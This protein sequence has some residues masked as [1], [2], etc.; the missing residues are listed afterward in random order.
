M[1]TYSKEGSKSLWSLSSG[2]ENSRS[3]APLRQ[4]PLSNPL[5]SLQ[6]VARHAEVTQMPL[7]SH[8]NRPP[9]PDEGS[10]IHGQQAC[11]E[12]GTLPT[13]TAERLCGAGGG[14]LLAR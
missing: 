5:S 9:P 1:P 10:L 7:A 13:V 12:K 8:P 3:S 2:M 11:G 6:R 14:R 4:M